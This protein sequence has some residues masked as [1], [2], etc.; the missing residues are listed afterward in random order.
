M[1]AKLVLGVT[2]LILLYLGYAWYTA[3]MST[4]VWSRTDIPCLSSLESEDEMDHAVLQ[5]V[6]DD[7]LELIP[8]SIGRSEQCIA[9]V[10]TRDASGT[11]HVV[12]TE[13][14]AYTLGDFFKVWN[15][16]F[17]RDGYDVDVYTGDAKSEVEEYL[18]LQDH[19]RIVVRYTKKVD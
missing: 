12:R 7:V 14:D 3:G 13:G 2:I 6:R 15:K 9:S 11:V 8:A 16:S 1:L 17:E 5:I 10:H 4:P 18:L 19:E